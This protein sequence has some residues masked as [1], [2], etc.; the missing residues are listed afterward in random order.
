MVQGGDPFAVSRAYS[1]A[2]G[3]PVCWTAFLPAH[4]RR[5]VANADLVCASTHE[6]IRY[7]SQ[8]QATL[9]E[10]VST[11]KAASIVAPKEWLAYLSQRGYRCTVTGSRRLLRNQAL[12]SVINA[13]KKTAKL[14]SQTGM[15]RLGHNRTYSVLV[16]L[17][18]SNVTQGLGA[19]YTILEWLRRRSRGV[20]PNLIVAEVRELPPRQ[21]DGSTV[22]VRGFFPAIEGVTGYLSYVARAL[23]MVFAFGLMVAAGKWF[24]L[25]SAHQLVEATYLSCLS[26][27]TLPS[28]YWFCNSGP[29]YQPLWSKIAERRGSRVTLYF[30]SSNGEP[31]QFGSGVAASLPCGLRQMTWMNYVVWNEHQ[32]AFLQRYHQDRSFEVVGPVDFS[33]NGA[34]VPVLSSEKPLVAIFDVT[35][36]RMSKYTQLGF[37]TAAYYSEELMLTFFADI[38]SIARTFEV[39]L[40][41]KGKRDVGPEFVSRRFVKR[42]AT[43]LDSDV[44]VVDSGISAARLCQTI[45]AAISIPL[46]STAIIAERLGKNSIYYD[47]SGQFKTRHSNDL[48]L[49][50]SPEELSA[51]FMQL[52]SRVKV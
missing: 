11:G 8:N 41:W 44:I 5:D 26:K 17:V 49:L 23:E 10:C 36:M 32:Q 39:Q 38:I 28:E 46:T 48:A 19:D 27:G 15:L 45:D 34:Q 2:V 20:R 22:R 9:I 12:Q 7:S 51:W 16:G 30:Y 33:D 14:L 52:T 25:L 35:P 3:V 13:L 31:A 47:P 1:D 4:L 37:G 40:I 18:K 24:E 43:L 29:F 6:A 21:L 50:G 42:R